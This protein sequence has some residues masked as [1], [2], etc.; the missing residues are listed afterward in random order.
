MKISQRR[1]LL[2]LHVPAAL[3]PPSNENRQIRMIM[4]IGIAHAAAEQ[5]QRVIQQ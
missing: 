4:R 3:H 2:V 5:V 1:R